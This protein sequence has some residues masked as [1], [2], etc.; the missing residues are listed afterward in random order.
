[1]P[2]DLVP[3]G[4]TPTESLA[5]NALISRGPTSAYSVS[6]TMGV[7]RAN[8]YQALNGLVSK[9]AASR[10]S[11]NPQV[12]RPIGPPALLAMV[13]QRE[14]AKLEAL[15][16]Q[17]VAHH[18]PGAETTLA[19]G[20]ER[21]FRELALRLAVRA[22]RVL[23]LGTSPVVS[24]LNPIWRKREADGAETDLWVI[25]VAHED[26][27]APLSGTVDS[28]TAKRYFGAN[29]ALLVTPDAVM[30]GCEV[31]GGELKGHWSSDSLWIG[32]VRGMAD[33]IIGA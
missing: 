33:A 29:P 11:D 7:A 21:S 10:V 17:V 6:K 28:L 1:M 14:V 4:F 22:S 15:E 20:S 25:G 24:G 23:C 19:F 3:F 2:I 31:E 26:F 9:G 32:A 12:F 30:I 18:Q 13:S 8:V 5:Y 27:P 16:A